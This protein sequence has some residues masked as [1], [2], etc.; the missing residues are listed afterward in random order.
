[1]D[2]FSFDPKNFMLV[3]DSN[4]TEELLRNNLPILLDIEIERDDAK[5]LGIYGRILKSIDKNKKSLYVFQYILEYDSQMIP[6][7]KSDYAPIF[8]FYIEDS[9]IGVNK[10]VI[11]DALH[12]KACWRSWEEVKALQVYSFWHSFIPIDHD[13]YKEK[14]EKNK[15]KKSNDNLEI[16][17]L[18]ES[19]IFEW[20]ERED[21]AE[22]VIQECLINPIRIIHNKNF[23][24]RKYKSYED[25]L[26]NYRQREITMFFADLDEDRETKILIEEAFWKEL[27]MRL[28]DEYTN[29]PFEEIQEAI[30]NN[31][32]TTF[33]SSSPDYISVEKKR[34]KTEIENSEYYKSRSRIGELISYLR[35]NP[36]DYSLFKKTIRKKWPKLPKWIQQI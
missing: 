30:E 12:Y 27:E 9:D 29:D 19:I 16:K 2:K 25:V 26:A 22:F 17:K 8:V 33:F 14:M 18:T 15:E 6:A 4:R 32:E 7:H 36:E 10:I 34:F 28:L 1:M 5:F 31:L 13:Y 23:R 21:K 35:N 20:W 24:N 3:E 11:F